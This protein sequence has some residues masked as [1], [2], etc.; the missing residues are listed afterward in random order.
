MNETD[1]ND[2]ERNAEGADSS[3]SAGFQVPDEQ[4]EREKARRREQDLYQMAFAYAGR[5]LPVLP[6]K[7]GGKMPLTE[8]G[9][10]DASTRSQDVTDWWTVKWRGAN[11]GLAIP[12]G[13]VVFDVDPRNGGS[14]DM[15]GEIPKTVMARTGGGGWHVWFRVSPDVKLRGKTDLPGIDVRKKGNYVVVAPSKHESGGTYEWVHK[16]RRIPS[17]TLRAPDLLVETASIPQHLL[18]LI[19]EQ[20][21]PVTTRSR[22]TITKGEA[23]TW[24]D[25][26]LDRAG[27]FGRN[28]TGFWLAMQL[29]D[30]GIPEDEAEAV[31][32]DYAAKVRD[33]GDHPYTDERASLGQASSATEGAGG[34]AEH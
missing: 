18:D 2:T 5:S 22:Q 12:E 3:T 16:V 32:I 34:A 23:S 13:F 14:L 15:L 24:L 29:R 11:I 17:P 28:E 33:Q 27:P 19:V 9:L 26:A 8:H 30:D 21:K 7:S 4:A 6:L 10:N 31:M 25:K 1:S 20:P